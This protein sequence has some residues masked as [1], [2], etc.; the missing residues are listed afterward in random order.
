MEK[1]LLRVAVTGV[2]GSGKTTVSSFFMQE[3]I[4][5]ISCDAIV[6]QLLARKKTAE[7]IENTFGRDV[8][9]NGA[10]DRKKL[11]KLVFSDVEKRMALEKLL[12]PAVFREIKKNILDYEKKGGIIV[13][14]IPLLFETK[15]EN[16][17]NKVIVVA[18]SPE[19]IKK[20]LKEKFQEEEIESRW[21]NQ[22]PLK[23]KEKK[24]DRVIDNSGS[25]EKTRRQV[26]Q[27]IKELRNEEKSWKTR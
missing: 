5:V 19:K 12:H 23:Q 8:V 17:F 15:S 16:L 11:G 10:V 26:K 2:F 1:K 3:G 18:S 9:K 27:L 7:K 14:E 22:I 24:A 20:R 25:V 13:V 4:P 6:H 21:R